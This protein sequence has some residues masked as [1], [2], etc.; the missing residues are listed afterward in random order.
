MANILALLLTF[1]VG[2]M[3]MGGGGAS[4]APAPVPTPTPLATTISRPASP[5]TSVGAVAATTAET[6]EV[7]F[8]AEATAI[9]QPI[10][11]NIPVIADPPGTLARSPS[12]PG[13]VQPATSDAFSLLPPS[14]TGTLEGDF[15]RAF[16]DRIANPDQPQA[17][18]I[19][20]PS[21]S[22]TDARVEPETTRPPAP[23]ASARIAAPTA[24]PAT[25]QPVDP[26]QRANELT[27]TLDQTRRTRDRYQRENTETYDAWQTAKREADRHRNLRARR[28]P[29]YLAH[30]RELDDQ[31]TQAYNWW[32]VAKNAYEKS[33]AAY[34]EAQAEMAAFLDTLA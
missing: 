3:A 24:A 20:I 4:Q 8:A 27:A 26:V 31:V 7:A 30:Q 17:D 32:Q 13:V 5:V 1:F 14:P 6:T 22:V 2:M 9:P 33:Q 29:Q 16:A 28:T 34:L 18:L 10:F 25:R 12:A 19:A 23:V 21:V 11:V 15:D